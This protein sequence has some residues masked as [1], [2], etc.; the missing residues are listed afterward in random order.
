[1]GLGIQGL[2]LRVR[3]PI[4]GLSPNHWKTLQHKQ[5]QAHELVADSVPTG[6]TAQM[7]APGYSK[8]SDPLNR[9]LQ[10]GAL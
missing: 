10:Q 6:Q 8:H 5:P 1:M 7:C 9:D 2:V 3:L 4:W